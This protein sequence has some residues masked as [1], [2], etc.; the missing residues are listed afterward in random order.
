MNRKEIL[1][2]VT[3]L[4]IALLVVR[5]MIYGLDE[6]ERRVANGIALACRMKL[7]LVHSATDSLRVLS[8]KHG[9]D[10]CAGWIG[11]AEYANAR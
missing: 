3:V 5:A 10:D 4:A 8:E 6:G 11:R 2:A 9:E 7:G 1:G